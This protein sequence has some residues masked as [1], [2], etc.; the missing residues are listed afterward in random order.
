MNGYRRVATLLTAITGVLIIFGW[1]IW[2]AIANENRITLLESQC[3][4]VKELQRENKLLKKTNE[5]LRKDLETFQRFMS[6]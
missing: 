3:G 6:F 1:V 5:K 2:W 4:N